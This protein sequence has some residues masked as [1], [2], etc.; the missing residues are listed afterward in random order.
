LGTKKKDNHE[1]TRTN[2]NNAAFSWYFVLVRGSN[3]IFFCKP[4]ILYSF[5]TSISKSFKEKRNGIFTPFL[6]ASSR[7]DINFSSDR[8][9]R[10]KR[11]GGI[12]NTAAT[13]GGVRY[14]LHNHPDT[15]G[16]GFDRDDIFGDEA[17]CIP[18]A[19]C[20]PAGGP[21]AADHTE[22][23]H[24]YSTTRGDGPARSRLP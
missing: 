15:R 1:I 6:F 13:A 9:G 7:R 16:Y 3:L 20:V 23:K 24:R 18:A 22:Y 14:S 10:D 21:I 8:G 2:T 17:A 5:I 12:Y 19:I 11:C 4:E